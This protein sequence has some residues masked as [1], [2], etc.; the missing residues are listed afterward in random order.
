MSAMRKLLDSLAAVDTK[1][2]MTALVITSVVAFIVV[3]GERPVDAPI[4]IP[5]GV[6]ARLVQL[7]DEREAARAFYKCQLEE[8]FTRQDR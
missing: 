3:D 7:S 1:T 4:G 5:E 6:D 2:I 8:C